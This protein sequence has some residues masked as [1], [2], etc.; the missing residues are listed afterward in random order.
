MRK[1]HIKVTHDWSTSRREINGKVS[2]EWAGFMHRDTR[3]AYK[4]SVETSQACSKACKIVK[5]FKIDQNDC[6]DANETEFSQNKIHR[7][8]LMNIRTP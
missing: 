6:E 7:Q 2:G 3:N 4:V 1:L 5:N 8:A